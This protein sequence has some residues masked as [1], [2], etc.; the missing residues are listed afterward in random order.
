MASVETIHVR[1]ILSFVTAVFILACIS[2]GEVRE[3][4]NLRFVVC[5]LK[6]GFWVKIGLMK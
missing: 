6:G 4:R 2:L 3:K 5:Y 1:L